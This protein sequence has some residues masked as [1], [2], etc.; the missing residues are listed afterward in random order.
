M[1]GDGTHIIAP[2]VDAYGSI[3]ITTLDRPLTYQE[4][5]ELTNNGRRPLQALILLSLE[6]VIQ[7][8]LPELNRQA[9]EQAFGENSCGGTDYRFRLV[10][11]VD[12][13][14]MSKVRHPMAGTGIFVFWCG[15]V[16]DVLDEM[17]PE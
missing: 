13:V 2:S 10:G 3:T 5:R 15:D 14:D 8:D 6:D 1:A 16:S 9:D 7:G 4:L 17:N 12:D 11:L